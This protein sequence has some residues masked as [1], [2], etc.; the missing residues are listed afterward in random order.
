MTS[1][2]ALRL[3]RW[4]AVLVPWTHAPARR[5]RPPE[6]RTRHYTGDA[7]RSLLGALLFSLVAFLVSRGPISPSE[8]DAFRVFND[9]PRV[10]VG[11]VI[12]LLEVASPVV[13]GSLA[14][15]GALALRKVRLA[16]DIA[17]AAAASWG[18][19]VALGHLVH[20]G[21]PLQ[22]A[23]FIGPVHLV[24]LLGLEGQAR[25]FPSPV[26]AVVASIATTSAPYLRRPT[27]RAVWAGVVFVGLARVYAAADLPLDVVGGALVGWCVGAFANFVLGAPTGHPAT[28]DVR[29]ALADAGL[30]IVELE[31]VAATSRSYV[32]Y[33]AVDEA[34]RELVVKVLG[35]EERSADL[36]VRLARF[37]ALRGAEEELSLVSRKRQVEHEALMALL[38]RRAGVRTPEVILAARG[39]RGEVFLVEE[40]IAGRT[41]D[42]LAP[43]ELDDE[44]LAKVWEQVAIMHQARIAHRDLRRHNILLDR[45]GQVW[46]LD[47]ASAECSASPKDLARDVT[48]LVVSLAAILGEE[49]AADS[50]VAAFGA[51]TLA[52]VLPMLQPLTLSSKT[53]GELPL[54]RGLLARLRSGLAARIGVEAPPLEQLTRV[55]LRTV[56]TVV[57]L[58]AAVFVLLPQ[59]GHFSQTI[60]AIE[61]ARWW[62]LLGAAGAG[63][64]TFVAAAVAQMGA[65]RQKLRLGRTVLVQVAASFAN[66]AAPAGLGGLGLNQRYIEK[67][68]VGRVAA[69]RAVG[70]NALAG[71]IV[72]AIGV[73]VALA[74]LGKAGIGGVSLPRGW[75]V[76][77]IVVSVLA[78]AGLVVGTLLRRRLKSALERAIDDLASA[79]R[80]PAQAARLFG[81]SAGVTAFNALALA[82]SLEAFGGGV[83]L[84][85]VFVVYLGGAAVASVSPTPGNLGALEAALVAGLTG[86]GMHVG[87]A[88]AGV[89]TFRLLT[90]WLPTAPGFWAFRLLQNRGWV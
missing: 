20:R 73:F 57:A 50:A 36:L 21:P 77:V 4:L 2:H 15:L 74:V 41:L 33:K 31:P 66:R 55:R 29:R 32:R 34:G 38:A 22:Y 11:P 24:S 61:R 14:L 89:L 69:V 28:Q 67:A 79:F 51:E 16:L 52:G 49:R 82:A 23:A 75:S 5:I 60:D 90:F 80:N 18:L 37:V 83:S 54:Q 70:L 48:E 76:L 13:A 78:L 71:A 19:A 10:L 39:R 56:V 7:L 6:A 87:P 27:S 25:G 58:G 84:W 1:R 72:H 45:A 63:G 65:V 26:V 3:P 46:I 62:W 85:K 17:I 81:G 88:V 12:A 53:L 68:G 8:A 35:R 86:V 44:L 64:A 43:E 59:V 47:F 30:G 40:G 42:D 9:L